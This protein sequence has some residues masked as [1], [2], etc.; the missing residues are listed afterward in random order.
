MPPPRCKWRRRNV[1][2]VIDSNTEPGTALS[3]CHENPAVADPVIGDEPAEFS[4]LHYKYPCCDSDRI[5]WQTLLYKDHSKTLFIP[6]HALKLAS[7]RKNSLI[8]RHVPEDCAPLLDRPPHQMIARVLQF[9]FTK[10]KNFTI[11][12]EAF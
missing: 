12:L 10:K 4:V 6:K 1:F 2:S 11:M 9:E 3:V 8:C 7:W 5:R